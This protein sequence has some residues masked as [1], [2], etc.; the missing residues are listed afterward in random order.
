M[1][2]LTTDRPLSEAVAAIERRTPF[3]S[4]MT[5][6]EWERVPA[7][8]RDRAMFSATVENERL[9]LA[10]KDRLAQRVA[11]VKPETGSHM[12][13]GLFIEEMRRELSSTGYQRG[14]ARRG[15]LRDLKSTARLGLI[16]DMNLSQ[17]AGYARWKMD[18]MPEGLANEPAYEL[19]RIKAK[20]EIRPWPLVWED[21]GGKFHGAPGKDYP[22]AKG[23]MIALKT[24]PIWRFISRFKTPWPPFDW[25]SGMGLMG[26]DRDEAEALG[27]LTADTELVPL[28]I[29]FN[30]GLRSSIH[31]LPPSSRETL[32]STFGDAI[33]I[34]NDEVLWH[35]NSTPETDEQR[36]QDAATTLRERARAIA[37]SGKQQFSRS[38]S[39]DGTL[40]LPP[41]L[42]IDE[43]PA[44]ILA[45]TSAVAVG[46]KLLYHEGWAG[47][48]EN[49]AA[50]I[51]GYLPD[52]VDVMVRDGHVY[53][54]RPD[55]LE[56]APDQIHVMTLKDESGM[57]LGY[58]QNLFDQPSVPVHI[59]NA[60]GEIIGG[61]FANPVS[62]H[63][64][65]RA[66]AKDFTSAL[67]MAVRIFIGEKEI[68]P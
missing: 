55:L 42:R 33:R 41:G 63:V 35:R 56:L 24:D 13:R 8:L 18:M 14:D 47:Y 28:S 62:A 20:V 61:F 49:L 52:N 37:D 65:A 46:R 53:A 51:R 67:D 9:L 5:S 68:L 12:D 31:G 40:S 6:R 16:W 17:A 36:K 21:H 10:M 4:A 26:I 23:R 2:A 48:A 22:N 59:R 29:A 58:G 19:V 38:R 27:L 50:L 30:A 32:R 60:A 39:E 3:G 45:S 43:P 7:D 25:G 57:L 66:R 54:W 1:L 34:D 15:S 64:Y 11:M 44:E